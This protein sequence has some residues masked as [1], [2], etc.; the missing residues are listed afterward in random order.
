MR[1]I[2]YTLLSIS[3]WFSTSHAALSQGIDFFEGNWE[4]A[5]QLAGEEEKLIFVDC[6]A[7]WCG[8]CK[9]MAANVFPNEEVG[10]FFNENFINL[11]WDM[12]KGKGLE[13]RKKF[14]VSAFPT[15]YFIDSSGEV[16]LSVT[17]GRD[18][19]GLIEL[20]RQA[21]RSYNPHS[22]FSEK[23]REGDRSTQTIYYHLKNLDREGTDV[24]ALANEHLG[25]DADFTDEYELKMLTLAMSESDS[26]L[27]NQFIA[28]KDRIVEAHGEEFYYDKIRTAGWNTLRK[29]MNFREAF[30]V[31]EAIQNMERA[32][33]PDLHVFGLKSH[34]YFAVRTR[35]DQRFNENLAPFLKQ[36]G[37]EDVEA[38]IEFTDLGL[39]VF[40]ET[41]ELLD[42]LHSGLSEASDKSKHPELYYRHAVVLKKLGRTRQARRAIDHA[43]EAAAEDRLEKYELLKS[44]IQ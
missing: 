37:A 9:R 31:D 17:G 22:G 3:M 39:R 30:L 33:L 14:P 26:R 41:S 1:Y 32:G 23:Y 29:A 38:S 43:I 18:V 13:F 35:D 34:L 24:L 12:E 27:F 4:E 21:I 44:Q 20:G 40:G 10:A 28:Q 6:Y 2:L 5:L 16:V 25:R 15:L 8:P 36:Y 42:N 11:K 19:N 7:V